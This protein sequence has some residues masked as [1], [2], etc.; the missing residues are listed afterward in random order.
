MLHRAKNYWSFGRTIRRAISPVFPKASEAEGRSIL[1]SDGIRLLGACS[2]YRAPLEETID[3]HDAP[4]LTISIP[5]RGCDGARSI[6]RARA[7]WS[8]S[9]L[10]ELEAAA[11][12]T[13]FSWQCAAVSSRVP[14][15]AV[16]LWVK[17]SARSSRTVP[18]RRARPFP[19]KGKTAR[20]SAKL[21]VKVRIVDKTAEPG[22]AQMDR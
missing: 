7:N 13:Y 21:G 18:I 17:G 20:K 5:E 3:W 12:V 4:P 15:P 11:F 19:A 1:H 14:V 22:S 9:M 6:V 16:N 2:L 8:A 10:R